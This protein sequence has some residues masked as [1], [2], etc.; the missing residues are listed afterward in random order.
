MKLT[1]LLIIISVIGLI[2][3][4]FKFGFLQSLY[5]QAFKGLRTSLEKTA[6]VIQI[7][8]IKELQINLPGPLRKLPTDVALS[9]STD[10]INQLGSN[11]VITQSKTP[12]STL[13]ISISSIVVATNNARNDNGGLKALT[14]NTLL[15][16]SAKKKLDDLFTKQYFEHVSPTGVVLGDIA[17]AVGYEYIVIGENLALGNFSSGQEFVDEWMKS[18]GHRANILNTRYQEIGVAVRKGM[19][20]GKETW[21]AVQHFGKPTSSCPSIDQSLKSSITELQTTITSERGELDKEK[22]TLDSTPASSSEYSSLVD[23]YNALAGE[24][25]AHVK[26]MDTKTVTYNN[27]VKSFNQCVEGK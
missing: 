7:E 1:K 23:K 13:S 16:A 22:A 25:N 14:E 11:L 9:D 5:Y 20:Q 2:T 17:S 26:L 8:K 19:Y 27:Q 10:T 15:D 6:Q 12:S 3:F 24:F 21:I 4:G 18:P